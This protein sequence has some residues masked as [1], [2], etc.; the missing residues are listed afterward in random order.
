[1]Y[2]LLMPLILLGCVITT[3]SETLTPQEVAQ[4]RANWMVANPPRWHPPYRVGRVF[5]H[6]RFEGVG[7]AKSHRPWKTIGTC[8]PRRRMRLVADAYAK[9]NHMAVRVRLWR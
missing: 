4:I 1:M 2:N 5:R 8:R 7:W 9:N 6:A 3:P